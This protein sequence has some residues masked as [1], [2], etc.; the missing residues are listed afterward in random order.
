MGD[1]RRRAAR[2]L[3][4]DEVYA[5]IKRPGPG[6][7]RMPRRPAGMRSRRAGAACGVPEADGRARHRVVPALRDVLEAE[8][9]GEPEPERRDLEPKVGASPSHDISGGELRGKRAREA[10]REHGRVRLR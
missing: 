10:P 9:R 5:R 4:R 8:R 1:E 7:A 2:H 6:E 3:T